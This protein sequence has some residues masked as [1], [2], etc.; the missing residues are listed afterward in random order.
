MPHL[1][2]QEYFLTR[3]RRKADQ[4]GRNRRIGRLMMSL[5][6]VLSMLGGFFVIN[7]QTASAAV[8]PPV[9]IVIADGSGHGVTNT[10]CQ[11]RDTNGDLVDASPSDRAVCTND[12]VVY[13]WE[14]TIDDQGADNV[15]LSQTLPEGWTWDADTITQCGTIGGVGTITNDGRTFTCVIDRAPGDDVEIRQLP[16]VAHVGPMVE[17]ESVYTPQIEMTQ[18]GVQ[19]THPG[20]AVTVYSLPEYEL[21]KRP[22]PGANNSRLDTF[23][24]DSTGGPVPAVIARYYVSIEG[25]ERANFKGLQPLATPFDFTDVVQGIHPE[26]ALVACIDSA[27]AA[28]EFTT[29]CTQAA[30]GDDIEITVDHPDGFVSGQAASIPSG[31]PQSTMYFVTIEIAL[32]LSDVPSAAAGGLDVINQ[33]V[34]FDP[35]G[36]HGDSNMGPGFEQGSQPGADCARL[37]GDTTAD[38][39][40]NCALIHLTGAG[41]TGSYSASKD[42]RMGTNADGSDCT[43]NPSSD[44]NNCPR[45]PNESS[46]TA[47]NGTV[48][49]GTKLW[50][51]MVVSQS[52]MWEGGYPGMRD[53]QVCDTWDATLQQLDP[54]REIRVFG[55]G[56][57]PVFNI[58]YSSQTHANNTA[59]E[60]APCMG[61]DANWQPTIAAAGGPEAITRVRVTITDPALITTQQVRVIVPMI[62]GD[63]AGPTPDFMRY[64]FENNAGQTVNSARRDGY[65]ITP[66]LVSL[67]KTTAGNITNSDAGA[68]ITYQLQP[69]VEVPGNPTP[70][71]VGPL[72]ITDQLDRCLS[73]PTLLPTVTDWT[74]EILSPLN[75]G[76]DGLAC[77]GDANEAGAT[78]LFTHI[79]DVTPGE[80]IQM[81]SYDATISPITN[82]G[83]DIQNTAVV[84]LDGNTQPV[85]SRTD[86]WNI[87]VFAPSA[88]VLSKVADYPLVEIQPDKLAWTIS[89]KNSLL[90]DA[91]A[92]TWVDVLPYV[93]DGRGS[94][95]TGTFNL[96]S[97]T[98]IGAGDGV[99]VKYTNEPSDQV[100][101]TGNP[102]VNTTMWCEESEFGDPDCPTSMSEVTAI[103]FGDTNLTR[104]EVGGLNIVAAPQG[105]IG[106]EFYVNNVSP[107]HRVGSVGAIPPTPNS[108]IDVV[109]STIGDRVWWDL[110][111]DGVQDPDEDGVDDVRVVL[112]VNGVEVE[113]TRTDANG[114]YRFTNLHSG[115]EYQ[116]VID[117]ATLPGGVDFTYDLDSG[118]TAPDE[119][120]GL[121]NLGIDTD[122]LDAD[123]GIVYVGT[124][125]E[126]TVVSGPTRDADGVDTL[127][128][129]ITV[130]NVGPLDTV[131][132][133]HD[134]LSFAD[135]IEIVSTNVTGPVGVTLANNWDGSTNTALAAGV[136]LPGHDTHTYTVTI[137]AR[138]TQ[139]VSAD[140]LACDETTIS[141]GFANIA[142]TDSHDVERSAGACVEGVVAL[143]DPDPEP[144]PTP[145]P[146]PGPTPDAAQT[147]RPERLPFTG[148][149]LTIGL[150][151]LGVLLVGGGVFLTRRGTNV[152]RVN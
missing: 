43:Y 23:E 93:G 12:S 78:V 31:L 63:I 56:A 81:I 74:M 118:L 101:Q 119:D 125:V 89:W 87:Q 91:G 33:I 30:D 103:Q 22:V 36:I 123:F 77:T 131:Y 51:R 85:A 120:S 100:D 134:E 146:D 7:Q 135:G 52:Q 136:P 114:E 17:N 110:N 84:D 144:T 88:L 128:Y 148:S 72:T 38:P 68:T 54:T 95:F 35:N 50:A 46:S 27:S 102:A 21:V 80:P 70:D 64:N 45:L 94:D 67:D 42:L 109:A 150:L 142:W 4:R 90:T 13:A 141:G 127:V 57:S 41:A 69:T 24:F 60:S 20:E 112:L 111:A 138:V 97:V 116:V 40:N 149:S 105:N 86:S 9:L 59:R 25:A 92:S 147:Q 11:I 73:M 129:E 5:A 124:D 14:I 121:I 71:P 152:R 16:L 34:D 139:S 115:T 137:Q 106:G 143:P 83:A 151:S 113:E 6:V 2:P 96:E 8:T 66:Q 130:T 62:A 1:T 145:T 3:S 39:N 37:E 15:E 19:T 76:D 28:N 47:E 10:Q 82:N 49:P 61:N 104:N 75:P 126:K 99:W 48:V 140:V 18:D 26:A 133:V 122:F 65:I 132:E 117:R 32:P 98:I 108:R 53:M 44:I 58:E 29:T 107:G 79:G 55:I